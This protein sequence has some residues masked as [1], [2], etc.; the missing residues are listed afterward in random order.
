MH[1]MNDVLS[2]YLDE[3]VLV[4]LE[5]MKIVVD[6]ET[7]QDLKGVKSFLGFANYYCYFVIGY[8]ELPSPLTYLIKKD[9]QW[10]RDPSPAGISE[11]QTSIVQCASL[12][13]FGPTLVV[14]CYYKCVQT[15][16]RG[17]VNGRPG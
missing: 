8:V 15:S 11:D 3:F 9:I 16:S 7:P 14:H 12:A 4:F 10:I 1:M 5:K 2:N 13:V 17:C 6:W